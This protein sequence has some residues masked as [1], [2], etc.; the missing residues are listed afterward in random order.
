M[1][2]STQISVK[3]SRLP[4]QKLALA[5]K[6][7]VHVDVKIT[8]TAYVY[9][10]FKMLSKGQNTLSCWSGEL[11]CVLA[12]VVSKSGLVNKLQ[13]PQ[14]DFAKKLLEE[15][16]ARKTFTGSSKHL[17]SCLLSHFECVFVEDSV[18]LS[19][20]KVLHEIFPGSYSKT[21]HAATARIQ[22][23]IDIQDGSTNRLEVQS[24]RDN[25]AKFSGDILTV[26]KPNDLVIRDLGYW[27]L[28][29]FK[30]I[31]KKKAFLLTRL[32]FGTNLYEVDT[33][34]SIDLNEQLKKADRK[35]IKVVKM[36]VLGTRGCLDTAGDVE[37]LWIP[38]AY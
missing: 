33:E 25:D 21:G 29:V 8:S 1:I 36:N 23:R 35:G 22:Y 12:K 19:L 24:F 37:G 7:N 3:L 32:R 18:C 34:V 27:S 16:L 14:V 31:V 11:S 17:R 38:L 6:F 5:C 10:F 2:N 20:P 4:I 13:Y 30:Q 28:K 9:S 15:L 26:L